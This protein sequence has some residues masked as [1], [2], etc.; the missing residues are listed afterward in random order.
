[1]KTS[2]SAFAFVI[3]AHVYSGPAIAADMPA[4]LIETPMFQPSVTSNELPPIHKRIPENPSIVEL[5]GKSKSLGR[6]GGDLRLLMGR[7]KDVRQMVVYGYS[8]LVAYNEKFEIVPDILEKLDVMEGRIFTLHLRKGHRWSDGHPFTAEDFRYWWED[9]AT[10]KDISKLGPPQSMLVKGEAPK[11]EVLNETTVRYSWSKP[12]PDLL[13]RLAG[14]APLYIYRPAHFLKK[15]HAKYQKAEVLDDMV[16]KSKRRSWV[17]LHYRN[18]RQYRNDNPEMPS[19]QPWIQTTKP[20]AKRFIFERNPYYYRIDSK[21]R[22][23]PYIDQVTMTVASAKLIPAKAGSGD[24]DLQARGVSLKNFPFLKQA[25]KRNNYNMRLWPTAKGS[26]M[27]LFPNLNHKDP[28]W[29]ELFRDVR[30]RR[31][32][33]MAIDRKQISKLIYFQQAAPVGNTVLEESP[34]Y[35]EEYGKRWSQF[36][37]KKANALLDAVGLTKRD[38]YGIRQLPNGQPLEISFET[39]G[40]E[41]EQTD[42]LQLITDSWKAIGVKLFRRNGKFFA[43]VSLPA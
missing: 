1:M 17:V 29:R 13:P 4:S 37:L 11:F 12:N 32:L 5:S 31:A 27:A 2:I 25:E 34:L 40:E 33:S 38:S 24:T 6:H 39:A 23:L 10:N 22:Q 35:K 41:L 8:R 36:D 9:M 7:A 15:F 26:Q 3:S 18:D 30:F 16:K 14:A 19:L 20:P 43:T 28:V 42:I 21:G